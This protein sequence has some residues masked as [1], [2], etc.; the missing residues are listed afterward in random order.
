MTT[1]FRRLS[2]I[3]VTYNSEGLVS[4]AL[5]SAAAAAREHGMTLEL[6]VVDNAS[7]DDTRGVLAREF[8][9]ATVIANNENVG[10]GRANNQAFELATGELWLLLNPDAMLAPDCLGP[11]VRLLQ[12][13]PSAGAVAPSIRTDGGRGPEFA[14]MS[15]GIRSSVGHFFLANRLLWKDGGGSW[16][17]VQLQRRPHLGPRPVDWLS[18]GVLLLRPDAVSM[19]AGFDPRFF[20]YGEDID[21]GER[22]SRAGWELWIVPEATATHRTASSQGGVS[23]RWVKASRDLYRERARPPQVVVFDLIVA[24]GLSLRALASGVRG[25]S[26]EQRLHARTMRGSAAQAWRLAAADLGAMGMVSAHQHGRPI[27]HAGR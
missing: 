19:V 16:R 17:G 27:G 5:R 18:A 4:S 23:T 26:A 15:P 24:L 10:F 25:G 14:G 21:F 6:I 2:V 11:L 8:P 3:T 22:L 9:T 13:R 12:Q 1:E 7:A 20:L